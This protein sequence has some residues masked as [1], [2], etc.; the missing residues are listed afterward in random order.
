M[1]H[2]ESKG[3]PFVSRMEGNRRSVRGK[4][5]AGEGR[6][7]VPV[8][9]QMRETRA[10]SLRFGLA[11]VQ[12]FSE[13]QLPVA[14]EFDSSGFQ[15][16]RRQV[17][18]SFDYMRWQRPCRVGT[19]GRRKQCSRHELTDPVHTIDGTARVCAFGYHWHACR[20]QTESRLPEGADFFCISSLQNST[21]R[22][23][24]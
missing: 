3:P 24:R 4:P 5:R 19:G 21:S 22:P 12:K 18:L 7:L 11:V 16:V 20:S 17:D 15:T 2:V 6:V 13:G 1:R 10:A 23:G 9:W 8:T 14:V